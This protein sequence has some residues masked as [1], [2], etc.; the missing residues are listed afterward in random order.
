MQLVYVSNAQ[1]PSRS[2][3]ALQVMRMC[4]AFRRAGAGVTLVHPYR[5][6]NRPEGYHDDLW[7]F[8]GVSERFEIVTLPTP[9]TRT[10]TAVRPIARP[11][12]AVPLAVY[13]AW[14]SRPGGCPFVCYGR[15]FLGAWAAVRLRAIRGHRSSCQGV[16]VEVHDEPRRDGD[17]RLLSAVDG[18]VVIS[19]AL[20]R[21][22]VA[23]SPSIEGRVWVEHDAV[24]LEETSGAGAGRAELRARLGISLQD[25]CVLYTGRVNEE[26][27]AGV[28]LEA[29]ALLPN[30]RF[31]LVGKVY[32]PQYQERARRLGNVTLT[33]FVSP[34]QVPAYLAAADILVLPS[35]SSL[36]Y[37]AYMSPLK[38]FEYMAS[39]K[40]IV[41]SNLPV[42]TEILVSERN[43]LLYPS[44]DASALA[45]AVN[46]LWR[47]RSL[48]SRL[49]E[50]AAEGVQDFTWRKRADRIL[51]RIQTVLT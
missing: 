51:A 47:D 27:G 44:S 24:D 4:A 13:L 48:G 15:S 43:A 6:G 3:N 19:E 28:L 5:I 21:R 36:P 37:A 10:L 18:V 50:N 35:T 42:F 7:S 2:T 9:L 20:R 31:V 41:A 32:E 14:R 23:R 11:V 8:Y 17:W 33:G 38:L 26:K 1:I 46:R 25:L 40:P 34:A 29:A 30:V 45:Y 49:A 39:G 16:F 12:E 22:L